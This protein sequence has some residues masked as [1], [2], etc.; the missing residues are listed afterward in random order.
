MR[1]EEQKNKQQITFKKKEIGSMFDST[2]LIAE[3]DRFTAGII[4]CANCFFKNIFGKIQKSWMVST[5]PYS[6]WAIFMYIKCMRGGGGGTYC[7]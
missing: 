3:F 5:Y 1:Y 7:E 4:F 2:Y 6:T